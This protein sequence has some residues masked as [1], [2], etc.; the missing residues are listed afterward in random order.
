MQCL[1]CG[2][3]MLL[4]EVVRDDTTKVPGLER[5]TFKCSACPQIARRVMF[6]RVKMPVS[7]LPVITTPTH[8][9]WNGVAAPN[10]WGK[11][12][13]T[14]RSRQADLTERAAAAKIAGWTKAVERV[15]R[16]QAALAEHAAVTSQVKRAEP[17]WAPAA[18]SSEPS[19]SPPASSEP[20]VPARAWERAVAKVRARQGTG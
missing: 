19:A 20:V 8:H 4:M 5:H 14:L 15:R 13:E 18:A 12:I 10:G 16:K 17:V 3:K 9:L 11:A 1:A 2:A 6:S 7:H